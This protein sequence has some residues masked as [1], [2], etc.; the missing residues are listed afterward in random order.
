MI[1]FPIFLRELAQQWR[2]QKKQ[3][4]AQGSLG[5]ENDV[6]TSNTRIAQRKCTIPQSMIK[7]NRNIIVL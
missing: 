3:N 6:Q 7:N 4:L 2:P 1:E 5:D